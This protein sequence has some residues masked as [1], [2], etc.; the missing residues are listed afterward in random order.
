M[1][2]FG[3]GNI[4]FEPDGREA[5]FGPLAALEEDEEFKRQNFRYPI[6]VGAFDKGHYMI[7]YI[8]EQ[9]KTG[10]AGAADK[11]AK[12]PGLYA[13]GTSK[14]FQA[15]Q[16]LS[17]GSE[18][19]SAISSGT[20]QIKSAT[21]N[22]GSSFT[23]QISSFTGAGGKLGGFDTGSMSMFSSF[24][25][26]VKGGIG[27]IFG[28]TNVL[29]ASQTSTSKTIDE[30]IKNISD[31]RFIKTTTR[32]KESIALYMPDTLMYNHT[33]TY[34]S[35]SMGKGLM[36]G[37]FAAG[38]SAVEAFNKADK[39]GAGLTGKMAAGGTAFADNLASGGL[40]AGMTAI[41]NKA[42]PGMGTGLTIGLLGQ[43]QN[44]MLEMAYSSPNF[45]KFQFDFFF[46][47]RDESEALEVQNILDRF[48]YHQAPEMGGF[49][50]GGENRNQGATM[51]PPSEF[52]IKFYYGAAENPNIPELA[53]GCVLETI[54][55]N[56]APN[57]AQ[58]YEVPGENIAH[59]GRTGM[60][61]G[62]QLTLNF[63][64][65]SI[66]T[67]NDLRNPATGGTK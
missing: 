19:G 12:I 56:Y 43:I 45:R 49:R 17:T 3:F 29:K 38:R 16:N 34:S 60:P 27:N 65:T 47:P 53:T 10:I 59:R 46:Y 11:D 28:E 31:S 41:G 1:S 14:G 37:L 2:L 21:G 66:L 25:E 54:D 24:G 4:K 15:Q 7:F 13:G 57:G 55:V 9:S 26:K 63:S 36:G 35:I 52:D 48:K 50:A 32:T 51:R 39:G 20:N 18:I 6:D 67:K 8:R 61:V 64:E 44:P 23:N 42:S 5:T 62:V 22:L 40:V 30:S 58:F 33:Q